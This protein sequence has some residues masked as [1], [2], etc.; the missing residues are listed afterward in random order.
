MNGALPRPPPKNLKPSA[1]G[2]GDD[3]QASER[4]SQYVGR[5]RPNY[6]ATIRRVAS[7]F[8]PRGNTLVGNS[9][10]CWNWGV[11]VWTT[12]SSSYVGK[13]FFKASR[14]FYA[15]KRRIQLKD[16]NH[17]SMSSGVSEWATERLNLRKGPRQWCACGA[18]ERA[19]ERA[20][21]RAT[22]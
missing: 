21:E 19:S 2:E 14:Q 1:R 10:G 13:G 18:S 20:R 11:D 4:D 8:R 6:R 7:F 5:G 12:I 9:G 3:V 22:Q 16:L 15:Y 17:F